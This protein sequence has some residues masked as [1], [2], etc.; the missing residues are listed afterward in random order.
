MKR[1]LSVVTLALVGAPVAES[2]E[3]DDADVNEGGGLGWMVGCRGISMSSSSSLVISSRR[4]PRV[5]VLGNALDGK[6]RSVSSSNSSTIVARG[7][8]ILS[9]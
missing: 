2:L 6:G 4:A 5:P 3:V 1:V 7:G 9:R 8:I